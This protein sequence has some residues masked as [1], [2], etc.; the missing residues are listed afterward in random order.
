MKILTRQ[1]VYAC[2]Y[3]AKPPLDSE[4]SFFFPARIGCVV[5][6]FI[7]DL[8]RLWAVEMARYPI[9]T[10]C[11]IRPC[12]NPS[13]VVTF[14]TITLSSTT[15]RVSMCAGER[16]DGH[17]LGKSCVFSCGGGEGGRCQRAVSP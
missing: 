12:L 6:A 15:K 8:G 16:E 3:S 2:M 13:P 10:T 11:L 1:K 17:R 9:K 5:R 14:A 7:S 4:S